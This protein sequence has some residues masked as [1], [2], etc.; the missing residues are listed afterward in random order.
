M[1]GGGVEYF[2]LKK[3]RTS[4]RLHAACYH[5]WGK[6]TNESDIMQSKTTFMNVGVTWDMN[7]VKINKK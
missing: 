6:S 1:A 7:I 5:S 4:L 3:K 2:P